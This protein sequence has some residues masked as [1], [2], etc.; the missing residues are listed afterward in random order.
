MQ[1]RLPIYALSLIMLLTGCGS[2]VWYSFATKERMPGNRVGLISDE[3]QQKLNGYLSIHTD[4]HENESLYFRTLQFDKMNQNLV[5]NNNFSK[6][7]DLDFNTNSYGVA[8]NF[9]MEGE[10]IFMPINNNEVAS[11]NLNGA[12]L[13]KAQLPEAKTGFS[14]NALFGSDEKSINLALDSGKIYAYSSD[15]LLFVIN[16][17]TGFVERQKQVQPGRSIPIVEKN[18]V[19]IQSLEGSVYAYDLMLENVMWQYNGANEGFGSFTNFQPIYKDRVVVT[20]ISD[21]EIVALN[22]EN[23]DEVWNTSATSKIMRGKYNKVNIANA[24]QMYSNADNFYTTSKWGHLVKLGGENFEV[25]YAKQHRITSAIAI[26]DSVVI[27]ISDYKYLI[28]VHLET[29]ELAWKKDIY[30]NDQPD[31]V[32]PS[33]PIIAD[34]KIYIAAADMLKIFDISSGVILQQVNMQDDLNNIYLYKSKLIAITK[35]G[36]LLIF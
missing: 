36:S 8:S 14:L 35:D 33:D 31:L 12:L 6:K 22:V 34:G 27:A 29:G 28:A 9:V 7:L 20:K 16:A 30:E 15:G 26:I 18:V 1:F 3:D 19:I 11:Y 23:G 25:L 17:E 13:W 2:D 32:I 5:H 21:N 4:S 10:R 24:N